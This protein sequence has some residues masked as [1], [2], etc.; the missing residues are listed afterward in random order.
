MRIVAIYALLIVFFYF[1][2]K[3]LDAPFLEYQI[4]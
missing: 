1:V 2:D 3:Q 4:V